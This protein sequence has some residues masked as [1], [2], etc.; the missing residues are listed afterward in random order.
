M[1]SAMTSSL[2]KRHKVAGMLLLC[3]LYEYQGNDRQ[4]KGALALVPTATWALT[5]NVF[6]VAP[7]RIG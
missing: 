5:E 4:T 6:N 2:P 7:M 3:T 1:G